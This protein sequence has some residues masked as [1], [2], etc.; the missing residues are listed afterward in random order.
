MNRFGQPAQGR[1]RVLAERGVAGAQH[2]EILNQRAELVSGWHAV[3]PDAVVLWRVAVAKKH[4]RRDL[5]H[6]VRR[7]QCLVA[8]E[9]TYVERDLVRQE[10]YFL[11]DFAGL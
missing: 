7:G 11:H 2:S 5:V 9:V 8:L 6:T 10:G 4:E 1:Q 3:Q